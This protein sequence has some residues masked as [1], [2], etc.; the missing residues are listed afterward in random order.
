MKIGQRGDWDPSNLHILLKASFSAFCM[1]DCKSLRGI[2]RI[3]TLV[4]LVG[5]QIDG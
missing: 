3:A 2:C 5:D 4:E 1:G